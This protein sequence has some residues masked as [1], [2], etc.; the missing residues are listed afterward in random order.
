MKRWFYLLVAE[1]IV[2][3]LGAEAKGIAAA[4]SIHGTA[5]TIAHAAARLDGLVSDAPV[6]N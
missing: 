4:H 6:S 1:K 2:E 3:S 5:D